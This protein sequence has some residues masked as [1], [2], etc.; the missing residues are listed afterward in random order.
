MNIVFA[1]PLGMSECI[2]NKQV[3][4]L[5]KQ[6]HSITFYSTRNEHEDVMIE[7]AK[8]AEILVI[9]NIPLKKNFFDACPKLKM[10]SVAFT[11]VDHIDL[12]CCK[13]W[14]ITICNAAGY[15]TQA[16]AELSIGM[17][18]ALYRNIVHCDHMTRSGQDRQ[19][20]LG[21]ELHGKT[22]GIIG[23]GAIGQRVAQLATAFGC[24]ILAY[25]RSK[26]NIASVTQVDK[27]QLLSQSD[28]ITL[29]LPLTADTKHFIDEHDFQ[30]MQPHAILINTAR[31]PV[32]NPQALYN[33]L[34]KGQIAGAAID[35]YDQEPPLPPQFELF[36]AP[37]LLMLPHI[38]YATQE[39]FGIRLDI[40]I[41][42][43]NLWLA[44]TPQ[45]QIL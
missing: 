14:G 30:L 26:K 1:E 29:H 17:M 41:Q 4:H 19:G 43:I 20:F 45:N 42:N 37:N 10:I 15:S 38:G 23:L 11:G 18:L 36:N 22:I 28:I 3:E 24:N 34:N 39:A 33:A 35:V 2:L 27:E 8:D 40:V 9:S 31:G 25:N 7:R 12:N 6:G 13:E 16:V 32:V 5:K 21:S 44:G